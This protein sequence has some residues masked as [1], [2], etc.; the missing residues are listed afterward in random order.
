MVSLETVG[1][2][3]VG[4]FTGVPA[5]LWNSYNGQR[6]GEALADVLFGRTNPSGRLPFT[7]YADGAALPSIEDYG[8]RAEGGSPGRTYEYY[9]GPVAFPFGYGLGYAGV[10]YG[11]ASVDR[12]AVSPD[13]T[14]TV[15][16]DVTNTGSADAAGLAA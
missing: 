8:I 11:P 15:T 7:W 6:G 2:V 1:Q 14:V 3:D 9:T 13:D 4:A 12:A 5:L 16:V 10:A